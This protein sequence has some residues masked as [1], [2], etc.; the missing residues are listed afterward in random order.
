MTEHAPGNLTH[1]PSTLS[2]V[3][4]PVCSTYSLLWYDRLTLVTSRRHIFTHQRKDHKIIVDTPKKISFFLVYYTTLSVYRPCSVASRITSNGFRKHNRGI[5][6]GE[7]SG[8][9][10]KQLSPDSWY[11][12]RY[13]NRVPLEYESTALPLPA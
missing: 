4:L 9:H 2:C 7:K 5:L 12:G 11:S 10:T 6:P 1:P 3:W 8:N 13:S